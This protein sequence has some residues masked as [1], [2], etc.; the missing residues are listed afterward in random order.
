MR[1]L[2]EEAVVWRVCCV[3]V[4]CVRVRRVCVHAADPACPLACHGLGLD[5]CRRA[6][7]VCVCVCVCACVCV[8]V[9]LRAC[10]RQVCVHAADPCSCPSHGLYVSLVAGAVVLLLAIVI[11]CQFLDDMLA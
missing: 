1:P 7:C 8:C 4:C 3:R 10:V 6:K 11:G 5:R 9:W 2:L